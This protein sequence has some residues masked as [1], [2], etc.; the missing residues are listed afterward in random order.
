MLVIYLDIGE[1]CKLSDDTFK[2]RQHVIVVN[3]KEIREM[4]VVPVGLGMMGAVLEEND[5]EI[6]TLVNNFRNYKDSKQIL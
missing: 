5:C 2:V 1:V 4:S 3:K 6:H